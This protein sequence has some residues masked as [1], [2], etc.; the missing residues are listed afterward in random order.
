[1]ASD[2]D[3]GR[4]EELKKQLYSREVDARF[5]QLNDNSQPSFNNSRFDY[6]VPE[7]WSKDEEQLIAN[8]IRYKLREMNKSR[9]PKLLLV[10]SFI[11]FLI[12]TS[13]FW[14]TFR[15]GGNTISSGNLNIAIA[16]PAAVRGGEAAPIE[17]IVTNGNSISLDA[18]N[19]KVDYPIG[20]RDSKDPTK[21]LIRDEDLI[22]TIAAG[23]S[24]RRT[25][26]PILIG[27]AGAAKEI[28]VSLEYRVA[29]SSAVFYKEKSVELIIS[30]APVN[31]NV[32][33][34]AEAEVNQEFF[35]QADI[36]SNSSAP[37][38]NLLLQLQSGFG[39]NL[40]AAEPAPASSGQVWRIG[41][42][43]PGESRSLVIR[44]S[45]T[46]QEGEERILKFIIG[47]ES[48][49]EVGVIGVPIID[50]IST[51]ALRRPFISSQL[52]LNRQVGILAVPGGS[53]IDGRLI[54]TNNLDV[55][56]T[57]VEVELFI[58]GA[59][60]QQESVK[61]EGGFYR[62]TDNSIYWNQRGVSDLA[63]M[64]PGD[65]ATLLFSLKSLPTSAL[66]AAGLRNQELVFAINIKANRISES[67]VPE[68]VKAVT[69]SKVKIT[70]V[71][72]LDSRVLR[73]DGP[74]PVTGP[75]PPRANQKTV[76]TIAWTLTNTLN[77][78]Y[79]ARVLA[80]LPP[81]LEFVGATSPA[82][83]SLI[84]NPKTGEISWE[85]GELAAY[86]GFSL[87]PR[88]VFFQVSLTPSLSQVGQ[89]LLL[90]SA[91]SFI[92]TDRF[93]GVTIKQVSKE[94]STKFSLDSSF[95][96]GDEFVVR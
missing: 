45:F 89:E 31:L 8:K 86:T 15:S 19:L 83:E 24:L 75:I 5:N 49:K 84:W 38:D 91:S 7:D 39:F 60:F 21:E 11:F 12:A 1:M 67:R 70:S 20:T 95:R 58:K 81:Y 87:P 3:K 78:I 30:S 9:V 51:I 85:V 94:L 23:E 66:I 82:N 27:E 37:T 14:I 29:G 28:K 93:T 68:E 47:T 92:G 69:Q 50:N 90:L 61:S 64:N 96:K 71:A 63:I 46:G 16:G 36:T 53:E 88:Q 52:S 73:G 17:I 54:L 76:Y 41:I 2:I 72:G 43:Q 35:I 77:D 57:D 59:V 4:I 18:V 80:T 55:R 34:P 26:T 44:G 25:V 79:N 65:R 74:L 40:L 32:S 13:Y 56:V 10:G 33:V 48:Q 6:N 62:S 22:G 42:L